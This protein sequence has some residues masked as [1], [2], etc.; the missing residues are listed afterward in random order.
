VYFEHSVCVC[1]RERVFV[2]ICVCMCECVCVCVCRCVCL[3]VCVYGILNE[4]IHIRERPG[5]GES[6]REI[7]C[8]YT[9]QHINIS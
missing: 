1:E 4:Y 2:C 3:F 9:H 8:A 5:E 7:R 6:K